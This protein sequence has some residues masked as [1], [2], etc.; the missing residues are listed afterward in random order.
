METRK[1]SATNLFLSLSLTCQLHEDRDEDRDRRLRRVPSREQP[2]KPAGAGLLCPLG[3]RDDL[4]HLD[5]RLLP[6]RRPAVAVVFYPAPGALEHAERVLGVPTRVQRHGRVRQHRRGGQQ[7]H[8]RDPCP[9]QREPPAVREAQHRE[10]DQLGDEDA[11]GRREL[12]EDVEGAADVRRSHL[13][14]VE[15]DGLR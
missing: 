6:A 13:G 4:G 9:G 1:N 11:D 7:Q 5:P 2:P 10:I 12:E 15:R 14:E 3:R 8:R